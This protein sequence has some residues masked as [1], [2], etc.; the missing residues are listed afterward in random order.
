MEKPSQS[1]FA[2]AM[3]S[4]VTYTGANSHALASANLKMGHSS[5]TACS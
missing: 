2:R 4:A 3:L 1:M 5:F